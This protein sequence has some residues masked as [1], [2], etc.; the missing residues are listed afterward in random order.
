MD[1][2]TIVII[3]FS[4]GTILGVCLWYRRNGPFEQY[5]QPL[6]AIPEDTPITFPL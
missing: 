6:L 4:T 1:P 3:V 5:H 2:L